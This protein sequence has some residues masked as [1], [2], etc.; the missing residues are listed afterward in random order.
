[1]SIITRGNLVKLFAGLLILG[2]VIELFIVYTY[3]PQNAPPQ[4]QQQP[5]RPIEEEYFSVSLAPFVVNAFT[6]AMLFQCNATTLPEFSGL[7]GKPIAIGSLQ[8]GGAKLFLAKTVNDSVVSNTS[9]VQLFSLW[10]APMCGDNV[11]IYREAQVSFNGSTVEMIS[12]V[13]SA[14]KS[15]LSKRQF[16]AYTD[17]IGRGT[18]AL[19]PDLT[20]LS[21]SE[22]N[23]FIRAVL[24]G[25]AIVPGS[26][27]LE[28]PATQAAES[29]ALEVNASIVSFTGGETVVIPLPWENR[30]Q[31]TALVPDSAWLRDDIIHRDEVIVNET[32]DENALKNLSFVN[33]VNYLENATV[34]LVGNYSDKQTVESELKKLSNASIVFP[35]STRVISYNASLIQWDAN[36][37]PEYS[38]KVVE[39]IV[40]PVE[41]SSIL[42]SEFPALVMPNASV[43]STVLLLVE[44]VVKNNVVSQ[45]KARQKELMDITVV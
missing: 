38:F 14:N 41:Q 42:P 12:A 44:V 24:V 13:N 2:F 45:L 18:V 10:L 28:Q 30:T 17:R 8:G 19:I 43:N 31:K 36:P 3:S 21:G 40:T 25:N 35:P 26:L 4:G 29:K 27:L 20:T 6:G 23:V 32:L 34:I 15:L 11:V 16:D 5:S 1:M 39:A 9:F 33:S 37:F 7:L 22:V